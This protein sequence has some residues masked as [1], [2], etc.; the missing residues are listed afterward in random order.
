VEFQTIPIEAI[1]SREKQ[2][3]QTFDDDFLTELAES[4]RKEGV[5]VPIIV[6]PLGD[7]Y[8][9]VA[10]E[11]RWRAAKKVGL[12][13]IPISLVK[14]D[15]KKVNE[16]ALLENVKRKD[17]SAWERE[18]AI[19]AMWK[20]GYYGSIEELSVVLDIK[21]E[22]LKRILAARDMRWSEDLPKSA[23]TDMITTV[24]SLDAKTRREIL[25]AQDR[26][27][28]PK[29]IKGTRPLIANL[30]KASEDA[31]PRLVQAYSKEELPLSDMDSIA[32]VVETREEVD[33]LLEAKKNL[34]EREF[35]S[36]ISYIKTE[37]NRGV[38]PVIKTVVEGEVH[39]WNS[40]LNSVEEVRNE[41]SILKPSKCKG[42]PVEERKRLRKALL[43][44]ELQVQ[45]MLKDI[46]EV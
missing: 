28:L 7:K 23:S 19:G 27:D 18:D 15:E 34:P 5:L 9:I 8:E 41:L 22:S 24:S 40:Y 25:D 11:Q 14:A 38:A 12:K 1:I 16:L 2:V 33:Q 30:K 6:R 31:R 29:D 36:I 17:L 42:W 44:I 13:E 3:R 26:G 4:I 32:E 10:G 37:K 46:E 43:D 20:S 39:L 45:R 35:K 21:P